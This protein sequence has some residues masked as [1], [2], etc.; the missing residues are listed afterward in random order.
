MLAPT[1][2]LVAELNRRARDHRLNG[3]VQDAVVRLADGNQASVGDVI[4]TRSND[5]RLRLTATD[6]VKNGDRWAITRIGWR[7]DPG[8]KFIAVG[9]CQPQV[10]QPDLQLGEQAQRHPRMLYQADGEATRAVQADPAVSEVQDGHQPE[11]LGV[12]PRTGIEV[13]HAQREMVHSGEAR[14][15]ATPDSGR[16]PAIPA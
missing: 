7:G 4:I 12:E 2:D 13:G 1:R 5:R 6:W 15:E 11:H 3:N 9:R 8:D 14:H 10:V 16:R